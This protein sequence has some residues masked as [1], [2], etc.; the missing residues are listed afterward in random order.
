MTQQSER[1]RSYVLGLS[2]LGMGLSLGFTMAAAV[3]LGTW[4]DG[5]A[6]T[7]PLF[8]VLFIVGGFAGFLERLLWLLKRNSKAR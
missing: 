1:A 2:L 5:K 7:S 4:L 6:G 8:V 3:W